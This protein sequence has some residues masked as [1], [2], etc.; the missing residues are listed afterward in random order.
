MSIFSL[1]NHLLEIQV[2]QTGAELCKI[3][4]LSN[5]TEYLWDADPNIW[6]SHSPLLFPIVGA[7][8]ENSYYFDNKKYSMQKHGFLRQNKNFEVISLSP[9]A[10]CLQL[11]YN[12]ETLLQYPFK[13]GF[14]ITYTLTENQI[15]INYQVDN[16]DK[17]DMY[18][19][20][21]G[22][23][24]FN[25]PLHAGEKYTDYYLEF[26]QNETAHI[27]SIEP[28][29]LI[30]EKPALVLN[31]SRTINLHHQLFNNDAL[32]FKNLKSKSVS[33][34]SKN[35][36]KRVQVHFEGFPFLGIWAKP[37]ANFICIEPWK[38]IADNTKTNQNFTTKEGI[39]KLSGKSSYKALYAIGIF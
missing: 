13:F 6:A 7:L 1:K 36:G 20:V 5:N 11:K 39:I 9:T 31:N 16:M 2:K 29:G 38:G 22:H 4:N 28:F 14:S 37:N 35:A 18:F 23:P 8:K 25:C 30:G 21:G 3:K 34:C 17:N 19:S 32:V 24:A 27:C 15:E 26:E 12:P 10:V 33:L